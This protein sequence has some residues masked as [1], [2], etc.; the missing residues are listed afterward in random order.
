ML[1]LVRLG[2]IEKQSSEIKHESSK[3]LDI[4]SHK[5][6]NKNGVVT[7]QRSEKDLIGKSLAYLK[8]LKPV[9]Y[10]NQSPPLSVKP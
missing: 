2:K 1:N 3:K 5:N 7:K 4:E 6:G 10:K 8:P 9:S